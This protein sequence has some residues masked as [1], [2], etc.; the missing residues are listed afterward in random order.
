VDELFVLVFGL[1]IT[2]ITIFIIF[3]TFSRS[4]SLLAEWAKENSFEIISQQYIWFARGPFFWSTS[5][6]QAI[7]RVTVQDS[8]GTQ[9]SAW[10]RVGSYWWGVMEK[11]VEARW[12]DETDEKIKQKPKLKNG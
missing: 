7:Y 11:K 5:R 8:A 10:V 4:E 9:R 6:S 3:W 12:D 1:G 2:I